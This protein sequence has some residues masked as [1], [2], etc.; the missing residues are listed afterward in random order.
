MSASLDSVLEILAE[1]RR[2]LV[3]R[4]LRNTSNGVASCEEL[5]D[6]IS[7]HYSEEQN[8]ENI[9]IR[10][11]HIDLPKLDSAGLIEYD[12]RSNTARYHPHPQVDAL[13]EFIDTIDEK[14]R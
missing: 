2:R 1:E 5:V 7:T 12:S 3:V 4:H 14:A 13:V 8:A 11:H 10:L 9:K 6:Y